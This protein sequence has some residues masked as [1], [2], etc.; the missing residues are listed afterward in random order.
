MKST[1]FEMT[2]TDQNYMHAEIKSKLNPENASYNSLHNH[3]FLHLLPKY[4]KIKTYGT[5][6]LHVVLCECITLSLT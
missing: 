2:L 3:L 6:I 5:V 1:Y 4:L